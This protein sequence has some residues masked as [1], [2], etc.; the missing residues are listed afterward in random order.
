MQLKSIFFVSIVTCWISFDGIGQSLNDAIN[1]FVNA[2]GM[3]GASLGVYV[4]DAES[5]QVIGEF[6]SDK[7]LAPASTTKLFSTALGLE[8]LGAEYKPTTK[9]LYHGDLTDGVLK[10]D[11]LI[12]G[13]GDVTLGSRY[14]NPS[15]QEAFLNDWCD[16]LTQKGIQSIE[17]TI[18]VSSGLFG[19]ESTPSDWLWGD[20]GNY[21]GAFFSG[22]M[23]YDNTLFYH[24][25]T[26]KM[27]STAQL[28]KTYPAMPELDFK[29]S[30]FATQRS[31]DNS[32]IYGAPYSNFREG[33]GGLPENRAEF[34]VKGS[35]PDPESM[36]ASEFSRILNQNNI[37]HE[38]ATF[39][40]RVKPY[41]TSIKWNP[42]FQYEGLPVSEIIRLTNFESINVYAEGMMRL[43]QFLQDGSF[44]SHDKAAQFMENYWK[45]KL[46]SKHLFLADGSGLARTNAIS[47]KTMSELLI[48][49]NQSKNREVFYA[50]LPVAGVSGTLKNVAKNQ[51][52]SGR[53]HAKSGTMRRTK[54]YAG[55][56]ETVSGK[57]LA[58]SIIANNY[59][60]TNREIVQLM[61]QLMNQ[62]AKY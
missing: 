4:A 57:R 6:Q 18:Y 55:Y 36:L 59:T 49:M 31:G 52:A 27:G 42:L 43:A 58:F 21:Y 15:S 7:L 53:V 60:C 20:M 22:A 51:A 10:G 61:E 19:N 13:G 34:V 3:E 39:S 29:S 35:L 32:Y 14:T 1:Q 41:S 12:I 28:I 44:S 50:S 37:K 40:T 24:F 5:K 25:K 2:K 9:L 26:G 23:I 16:S 62:L 11:I 45:D 30:I 38:G 46:N 8:V 54:S 33:R 56:V 17:G 48:Y 47:A